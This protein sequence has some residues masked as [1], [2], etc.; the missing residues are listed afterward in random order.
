MQTTLQS[1]FDTFKEEQKHVSAYGGYTNPRVTFRDRT[2]A[3]WDEEGRSYRTVTL[4]QV[5]VA[6]GSNHRVIGYGK[7][8]EAALNAV[9]KKIVIRQLR[10]SLDQQEALLHQ[11]LRK[12]ESGA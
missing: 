10:R 1:I 5:T 8:E 7:N 11:E 4:R 2:K 3:V 12:I 6:F 9:L